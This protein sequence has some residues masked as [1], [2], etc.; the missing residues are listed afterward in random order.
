MRLTTSFVFWWFDFLLDE[1]QRK[2]Q[3]NNHSNFQSKS[4]K[5]V[6][7]NSL[8]STWTL[9]NSTSH[10]TRNESNNPRTAE[11]CGSPPRAQ[12][13]AQPPTP[14]PPDRSHLAPPRQLPTLVPESS[15][16]TG[17]TPGI[18]VWYVIMEIGERKIPG[19][20]YIAANRIQIFPQIGPYNL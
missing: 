10:F 6:I 4:R 5:K 11:S 1:K 17:S 16:C 3:H 8:P 14:R 9:V 18:C 13:P 20:L 12:P 15:H 7:L 2:T 19:L